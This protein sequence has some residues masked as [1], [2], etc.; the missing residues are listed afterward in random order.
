MGARTTFYPEG[1]SWPLYIGGLCGFAIIVCM[2]VAFPRIGGARAMALM[3]LGQSIAAMTIDHLGLF[4][5][6]HEPVTLRR[7]AGA[8][9]VACGVA[10]LRP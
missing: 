2:A 4:G 8:L 5:M 1:A 9:M 7:A 6:P 3:V 10:L